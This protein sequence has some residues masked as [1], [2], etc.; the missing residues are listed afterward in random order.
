MLE[1]SFFS[2][3]SQPYYIYSWDFSSKSA[4][5]RALHY[6]CHALNE[7][8]ASAYLVGAKQQHTNLRT[9]ILT[10]DDLIR[11]EKLGLSPIAVY[12]EIVFGNPLGT[13]NVVRWLL[14][15]AGYLGGDSK[16]DNNEM[17]Y[18]FSADF[19]PKDREGKILRVPV[20]DTN[21][22]HNK[23]NTK[24]NERQGTYYYANKYLAQGGQLTEHIDGATSL[25]QDVTITPDELAATLRQAA[26]LISYE[27][28]S[29]V[30]EALLCGCP[31]AMIPNEHLDQHAGDI[32]GPGI[33][34]GMSEE[35]LKHA[36]QTVSIVTDEYQKLIQ[37]CK[38]HVNWF[39]IQTQQRFGCSTRHTTEWFEKVF[40]HINTVQ[41]NSRIPSNKM[42]QL[43][44]RQWLQDH[45]LSEGDA[46]KMANRMVSQ[47]Q[48]EP[49]FHL[50]MI[51][52]AQ[53]LVL[54]PET[55]D[56]L[57]KQLYKSWGLTILSNIPAP[58][59]FADV[60]ANIEW[61]Q[62]EKSLNET[63]NEA[64]FASGLDWVC[65][66]MPGDKLQP[67]ALWSFSDCINSNNQ[68]RFIYS[69][70][71]S[72]SG[73][74]LP[75]ILFKPD[76]NLELLKSSSYIGRSAMI[77]RDTFE[78]IG[79]YT[80]LA[81]VDITDLAFHVYETW[82]DKTIGHID[83]VLYESVF[84]E[85]DGE[86]VKENELA[87]R[88][89]HIE[90]QNI[91]ARVLYLPDNTFQTKYFCKSSPLVSVVIANRNNASAIVACVTA[92]FELTDYLNY[93]VV[94]IDQNSDIEDMS[95]IYDDF[96]VMFGSR[97]KLVSIDK[98]SYAAAVNY[99]ASQA[100]GEYILVLSSLAM[101][102]NATWM[103]ELV[104]L[105]MQENNG[106]VG[107]K[108]V[109]ESEPFDVIHAG[110]VLGISNDVTGL[111]CGEAYDSFSYMHRARLCQEYSTVSSAAFIVSR[112]TFDGVGGLDEGALDN[113]HY[114]VT[115]FCLKVREQGV[116]NI[117]SPNAVVKQLRK[118]ALIQ[119]GVTVFNNSEADNELIRRWQKYIQHEPTYNRNLSLSDT[120]FSAQ[121]K[122][123]LNW[124]RQKDGVPRI[125]AFPFSKGAIGEFRVRAPLNF[126]ASEGAIETCYLPNHEAVTSPFIPSKFE[127]IRANPDILYLNYTLSNEHYDFIQWVKTYSDTFIIFSIDDLV[128]DLPKKNEAKKFLY[129]DIR[130]RLRRTLAL[131]DRLIVSTQPL[132]D[133]FAEYCNDIVVIPNS[134]DIERWADV[135]CAPSP[136][137]DKLRIGWAGGELHQDDLDVIVEVVK[138][139]SQQFDWVFMGMCP[140]ELKPYI[141]EYHS[142]VSLDEYPEKMASLGVDLAIAPLEANAFNEAKSNLRLLEY[143]M[144]GWP[145]ICTDI[146]PYRTSNPPVVRVEN[147]KDAWSEAILAL[148]EHP[149]KLKEQ[150]LLLKNWVYSNY[151]LRSVS[152]QWYQALTDDEI[153]TK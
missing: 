150:G 140:E 117:F 31:V 18:A 77:R 45:S 20:V 40:K 139:T 82:S 104:A 153:L 51:V 88:V 8:G 89:A 30:A 148:T 116:K 56:S 47:W 78:E 6:L 81:Y 75:E 127:F 49:T 7:L 102:V 27:P 91:N 62:V 36:K 66:V 5:I 103:S 86:L 99:G 111:S 50:L 96:S 43:G 94:I 134:L 54:L 110:G 97:F 126:L 113:T 42:H 84:H 59:A 53:E 135:D 37:D 32:V 109:E 133:A 3:V 95:Y 147:T 2:T 57:D 48:Y 106:V 151:N 71:L 12:P 152:I 143:G 93:E 108:T 67:H 24:D 9:P 132:A 80:G 73:N 105:A 21:V 41:L 125:I 64:V 55:F 142:F 72:H 19:L 46:I 69:D 25:C 131:C 90:R 119:N 15:T 120:S 10:V 1:Y 4:G 118:Q 52:N 68:Y 28:S 33:A 92:L 115:D 16:F 35:S 145:V 79:G 70:E 85:V 100:R 14:N 83:D 34:N 58:D 141:H 44:S 136:K 128:T 65:Q 124:R 26:L 112:S 23:N 129:K 137:K 13:D 76:F 130:H 107:V 74:G 114:C 61:V 39:L 138:E 121:T 122:L 29:I 146:Y 11:H 60:P 144:L 63:I 87:V 101:P 149:G 123:L 22:F 98:P 17:I 38:L